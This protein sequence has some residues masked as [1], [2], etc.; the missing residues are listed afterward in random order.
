MKGEAIPVPPQLGHNCFGVVCT[1]KY[2]VGLKGVTMSKPAAKKVDGPKYGEICKAAIL[3]LKDRT[4]SSQLAITKYIAANYPAAKN[5]NAIKAALKA[6]TKKGTFVK[7]KASYKVSAEA[8]KVPKKKI[9]KKTKKPAAAVKKVTK[10]AAPVKKT[11]TKKVVAEKPVAPKKAAKK[12]A[13]KKSVAAKKPAAKK[14]PKKTIV[15]KPAAAKVVKAKKSPAK[16]V[17]A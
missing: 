12:P 13:A 14:G 10:K 15:K 9:A 2:V 5:T 8:K 17:A 6:G 4:G 3:A 16:K 7:V 11:E 1:I